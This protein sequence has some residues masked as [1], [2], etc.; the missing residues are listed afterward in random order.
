MNGVKAYIPDGLNNA[1]VDISYQFLDPDGNTL[2]T[3]NIP[4]GKAYVTDEHGNGNIDWTINTSGQVLNERG[5]PIITK[6][7]K[8]TIR[9]TVT[10]VDT[11]Q[12]P[13]W[14]VHTEADS[15]STITIRPYDSQQYSPTGSTAEGTEK[16][17]TLEVHPEAYVFTL[18]ITTIDSRR[19]PGQAIDFVENTSSMGDM[20]ERNTNSH[21]TKLKWVC[22]DGVTESKK[23]NEPGTSTLL[24]VGGDAMVTTA[25][26]RKAYT[27]GL[28]ENRANVVTVI[29]ETGEFVPVNVLVSRTFG[30]LN[31]S[32]DTTE[33]IRQRSL[34]MRDDDNIYGTGKSS[35]KWTHECSVVTKWNC[36]DPGQEF[37]RANTTYGDTETTGHLGKVRYLL[38]IYENPEPDVSKNTTTPVITIG[39]DIDWTIMLGNTDKE[40]NKNMLPS[41]FT[42]VDILPWS[43]DGRI[44]PAYGA[45][46]VDGS[47][48]GGTLY[49]KKMVVDFSHS[50]YAMQNTTVYYTTSTAARTAS[51]GQLR[52]TVAGITWTKA[53][54]FAVDSN[55]TGFYI[56]NDA[57]AIRVDTTLD[58]EETMSVNLVANLKDSSTQQ[59]GDYYHNNALIMQ[60]KGI[61]ESNVVATQVVRLHIA[62]VVWED[63]DFDGLKLATEPTISGVKVSIYKEYDPMNPNPPVREIDG[64][65]LAEVYDADND[66]LVSQNTDNSGS[67]MFDNVQAGTYYIVADLIPEQYNMTKQRAGAGNAQDAMIDSEAETT[68][69]P[70]GD[71][72]KTAW[73]KAIT[74]T[75]QSVGYQ[76]FGLQC[77]LGNVRVGKTVNE[78]Y[79]PSAMTE[80]EREDYRIN[81]TFIL[82]HTQTGDEYRRTI[83]LKEDNI[84]PLAGK[85]QVWAEFSDLPLGTYELTEQFDPNYHL[86]GVNYTSSNV[87]YNKN[88][89]KTIVRVTQDE[90]DIEIWME[91]VAKPDPPA[92]DENGVNNP[93]KIRKP[94]NL[95]VIYAGADPI[96]NHAI[97]DYTFVESDFA[98]NKQA[99]DGS[100][101]KGDIIVTYDDGSQIKL[102]NGTLKFNQL[103]FS[104]NRVE[105]SMNS[106]SRRTAIAVYY[107]ERGS[108]VRDSFSVRVD[109][110]PYFRF[111]VKFHGNGSTFD[112]GDSTNHVDFVY[113]DVLGY[114]EV[115]TGIYKDENNGGLN[116]ITGFWQAGWNTQPDGQGYQYGDENDA[117]T[118][119]KQIGQEKRLSQLDLYAN[120]Q[121]NVTFNA[122]GGTLAGG[123]A[124]WETAAH[125]N[126]TVTKVFSRG[127]SIATSLIGSKNGYTF[128]FWNTKPDGSGEDIEEY[129]RA[130]GGCDG[131]V[132]FYAIY[133]QSEFQYTGDVQVFVAPVDGWYK[134]QLWGGAGLNERPI[135]TGG[136]YAEAEIRL[137][138]NR[139]VYVYVGSFMHEYNG[140]AKWEGDPE[141]PSGSGGG[142]TDIR[143]VSGNWYDN[144][145]QRFMVAGAS[146]GG[147]WLSQGAAGGGLF[148][149]STAG[150]NGGTQTT[151]SAFGKAIPIEGNV[152]QGGGGWYGGYSS[153]KYGHDYGGGGGSGYIRG[154]AGC[155]TTYQAIQLWP[156]GS[157]PEIQNAKLIAGDEVMPLQDGTV[158]INSS[159]YG[160]AK[161][162]LVRLSQ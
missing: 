151:G 1:F 124:N 36:N 25:V 80:Q 75:N 65:K 62:G 52:G 121:T 30:D 160:F 134:V 148:G 76:N 112:T 43:G 129:T 37:A 68:M 26:P 162:S 74:V 103:T 138:K 136:G 95:E 128:V 84:H 111:K 127:Q 140:G 15:D 122:N 5:N 100:G 89:G 3:L 33:Q 156:D 99:T 46:R 72:E 31:K 71:L 44:D 28:V 131:P 78:I 87:S 93:I 24:K 83:Y 117:L 50:P 57:T 73:I 13:D 104:P 113:N 27:D 32:V 123:T 64:I 119:L 61:I 153:R 159:R 88:T 135:I 10:P 126:T 4:H 85:P 96:S 130:H 59:V 155:D 91:N 125:G 19:E 143:P 39:G 149:K 101:R 118:A 9:A 157:T 60:G 145:E 133:Y 79:Y 81:C 108:V 29:G 45:D 20:V 2:G 90:P 98:N 141:A 21:F 92:G 54:S 147:G 11:T 14:H 110:K 115:T 144:L 105:S 94:V 22:T 70:S 109:L 63:S 23:N 158:G 17:L 146:G 67:Y 40:K 102:S 152:G 58:W 51:E 120:W 18:E 66:K 82:K 107:S 137:E 132:T 48:F 49:Y 139:E 69:I 55:H 16:A 35:V 150:A 53:D 47:Q 86:S 56:S 161:F 114:N 8:Y 42:M 154:M 38:H 34:I 116:T 41:E 106:S 97:Y 12:S 6:S 77:I 142:A 7:G